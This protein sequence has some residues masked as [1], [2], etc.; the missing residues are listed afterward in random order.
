MNRFFT[1]AALVCFAV[2]AAS[3][4]TRQSGTA[5][6]GKADPLHV[7][8]ADDR[9]D[10]SLSVGQVKCTWTKPLEMAGAKSKEGVNAETVEITGN[11]M[12]FHGID[13]STMDSGDK[14]FVRYHG[15][16]T[17]KDGAFVSS[18]GTWE[19]TGGTGKLKGITGKSTFTCAPSG[20]GASCEIEG[21]YQLPK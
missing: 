11:N 1:T 2:T 6:C 12:R 14:F 4:Q 5:Q 21:D 9:P 13:V 19:Y 16:G 10:H 18:K 15:T 20:D 3:A 17:T 7:I 8:P